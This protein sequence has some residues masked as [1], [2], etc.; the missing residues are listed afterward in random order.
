MVC[1]LSI[2]FFFL[3]FFFFSFFYRYFP[4]QTLAIRKD[5]KRNYYFSCFPLA[6]ANEHSFNLS[7]FLPF[8][9]TQSICNYQIDRWWVLFSLDICIFMDAIKLRSSQ[10]DIVR[11]W[12]H[13]K[14]SSFY[15]KANALNLVSLN[16]PLHWLVLSDIDWIVYLLYK[17][18]L[19]YRRWNFI[20]TT[21]LKLVKKIENKLRTFWG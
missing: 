4:W 9:F 12:A 8:I 5:G 20:T 18:T 7:R 16:S 21:R 1:V 14:L 15:Y 3:Y 17:P 11:I 13:I 10:S 19:F 6:P 2:F